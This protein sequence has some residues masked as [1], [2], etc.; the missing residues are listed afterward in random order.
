MVS[1]NTMY[2]P[3]SV[4]YG[5]ISSFLFGFEL[6]CFDQTVLPYCLV[7]I[8]FVIIQLSKSDKTPFIDACIIMK[9]GNKFKYTISALSNQY[10]SK[11]LL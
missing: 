6:L 10:N 11:S 3:S 8:I 2:E 7:E 4:P 9:Y 5:L 1:I